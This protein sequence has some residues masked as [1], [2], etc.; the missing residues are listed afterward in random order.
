MDST[1]SIQGSESNLRLDSSTEFKHLPTNRLQLIV[2][3]DH[4]LFR[5]GLCNLIRAWNNVANI[6]EAGNAYELFSK[7]REIKYDVILLD[8]IMPGKNG[9][10]VLTELKQNDPS[11]KVLII[12]QNSSSKDILDAV[13]LGAQ[14]FI[15][16][17]A[18]FE[19]LKTAI[20]RVATGGE[21]YA[22]DILRFVGN[23]DAEQLF[24]I[25]GEDASISFTDRELAVL[26][27]VC[28]QLSVE[29]TASKL[30][31]S[32]SSV[33]KYRMALLEKTNSRNNIGILAFSL[34]KGLINL[35]DI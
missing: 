7:V 5:E 2:L 25:A 31:L 16:K 29:E 21:Y 22:K 14:G 8:L 9:L 11:S 6:S 4:D 17:T 26:L 33:K 15:H 3:D 27:C 12:S 10:E 1:S 24:S 13:K 19:E 28:K 18:R 20:E 35:A 23:Y 32:I 34:K 30:D